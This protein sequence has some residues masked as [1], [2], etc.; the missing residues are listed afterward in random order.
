M[1]TDWTTLSPSYIWWHP[2]AA[3]ISLVDILLS[4]LVVS[5][6]EVNGHITRNTV[7]Q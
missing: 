7:F 3:Q 6:E 5:V 1:L 4:C 2:R